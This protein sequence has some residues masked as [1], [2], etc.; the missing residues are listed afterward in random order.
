MM[1]NALGFGVQK[2]R[3]QTGAPPPPGATDSTWGPLAVGAT[4][5]RVLPGGPEDVSA[6]YDFTATVTLS[7]ATPLYAILFPTG[8]RPTQAFWRLPNTNQD[9]NILST[10]AEQTVAIGGNTYVLLT[11]PNPGAAFGDLPVRWVRP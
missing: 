8:R 3:G 5:S 10:F 1:A 2:H 4:P 6:A 7:Q 11:H 9:T